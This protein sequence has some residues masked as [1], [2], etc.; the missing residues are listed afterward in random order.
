MCLPMYNTVYC[1]ILIILY[2]V[3]YTLE[4]MCVCVLIVYCMIVIST[5]YVCINVYLLLLGKWSSPKV[6]G[7]RPPPINSFTLTSIT[8]DSAIL[9]GGFTPNGSSNNTYIVNFSHTSVVSVF[10]VMY[11]YTLISLFMCIIFYYLEFF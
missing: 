8:N 2:I 5:M 11:C 7:D 3:V 4:Y 9:F 10:L 6:T 1:S